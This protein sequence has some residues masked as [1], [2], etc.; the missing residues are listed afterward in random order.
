MK[1]LIIIGRR[2][3]D[4]TYGNTYHSAEICID[5]NTVKIPFQYGYGD[6]YIYTAID[7]LKKEKL[8]ETDK[9]VSWQIFEELREQGIY[10]KTFVFDVNRKKDL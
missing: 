3:F 2:W 4:K 9:T 1:N 7:Y 8:I 10:V 6:Q 5:E